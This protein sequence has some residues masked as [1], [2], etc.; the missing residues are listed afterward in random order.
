MISGSNHLRDSSVCM[1]SW[2][3]WYWL[4]DGIMPRYMHTVWYWL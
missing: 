4:I 2:G 3:Q 1:K